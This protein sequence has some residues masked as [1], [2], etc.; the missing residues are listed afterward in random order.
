M[1]ANKH[2]TESEAS[3]IWLLHKKGL[4]AS[5][6]ALAIERSPM[7]VGRVIDIF[8]KAENS[9]WDAIDSKYNGRENKIVDFART[10][11]GKAQEQEAPAPAEQKPVRDNTVKYLADVLAE[12]RRNNELLE[13][14]VNAWEGK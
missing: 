12:L 14:L 1:A 13:R 9:E 3:R 7:S 8:T 11:F 10:Y 5:S 2:L 6:I 4:K